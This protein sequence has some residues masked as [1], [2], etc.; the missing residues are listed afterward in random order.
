[1]SELPSAHVLAVDDE[2][3]LAESYAA[4]IG[5]KHEVTSATS[6]EEALEAI[7]ETVDVVLVDRR[8]PGMSGFELIEQVHDQGYDP[9][10]LLCSAV[11]PGLE[12]LSHV[13]DDY[14]RK[15]VGS[16]ELLDTIDRQHRLTD[17]D[18]ETRVYLALEAK[19]AILEDT[20][21][22][23]RLEADERFESL[24]AEIDQLSG[25]AHAGDENPLCAL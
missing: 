24:L 3:T 14:L 10:I 6:G 25:R 16:D 15:P 21:A 13:F 19:R 23:P 18:P 8:M 12:I 11:N 1:M 9:Q 17:C 4:M 22:T 7:D 2:A 5:T 20:W